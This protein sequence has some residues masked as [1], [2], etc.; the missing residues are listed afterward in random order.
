MRRTGFNSKLYRCL[1][2]I[3]LLCLVTPS[4]AA[5]EEDLVESLPGMSWS[6][7]FKHYS[8]YLDT[9]GTRHLHYW[10]VESS[11]NPKTDPVVLW[12]NGGPGCSSLDGMLSEH[13]PFHAE[14]DGSIKPNP[15]AWNQVANMVYLEAPAGVGFSYADNRN[16]TTDDDQVANDNHLAMRAF[17]KKF[18][19]YASHD[20]YISGESYGGV[21]VPTLASSIL[22]DPS[23]NLKGFIV[24]NGLSSDKLNTNSIIYFAYYHGLIG[25]TSW[26]ALLSACCSVGV[27]NCDFY[28]GAMN[29]QKCN[30][31]LGEIQN[32]VWGAGI[33]VY[34]M[35]ADCPGGVGT[36][37]YS[38]E[39]NAFVTSRYLYPFS[40]M[41]RNNENED[42][43]LRFIN[44][45]NLKSDPPCTDS[46]AM[47][48]WLNSEAVKK[49]L[50]ISP[51]AQDWDICSGVVGAHYKRVY[52]NM[53]AQYQKALNHKLRVMVYNGDIDM[54]CNFLGDEWFVDSLHADT[55]K[56]RSMWYYQDENDSKQVAG[57][58][59]AFDHL[60][61][62]TIRGAG[63][64]V[65]SDKPRPALKMFINFVQNQPMA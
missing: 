32:L 50:H 61:Y 35:Y 55:T 20:F 9:A 41:K 34:N 11:S 46:S 64:M 39:R 17:F 54:A 62:V 44:P 24:G 8:G 51:K 60:T 29:S 7:N 30:N 4:S 15:F 43:V 2:G 5:P 16:Y 3:A 42:A 33:N 47:R 40:S 18:P 1:I 65:P 63:H 31:E 26:S 57:F 27:A 13:G 45:E 10:F 56:S 38:T 49:A 12:M 25:E 28:T 36:T 6:P 48:N 22:D 14:K 59:K 23:I 19:E 21:Y 52:D 58:F 53:E 37:Y